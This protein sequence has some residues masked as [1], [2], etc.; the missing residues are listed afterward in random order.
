MS[1]PPPRSTAISRRFVVGAAASVPA[2]PLVGGSRA[3]EVVTECADWMSIDMEMERLTLRW[4][5]LD[6]LAM[7]Q[8]TRT[9]GLPA[10]RQDRGLNLEMAALDE[11]LN[12]L[13]DER[14]QRL[15]QIAK[16]PASDLHGVCG[17]LAV[18]ARML[19]GEGGPIHQIVEEAVRVLSAQ[20]CP[21]CGTRFVPD[22]RRPSGRL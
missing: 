4:A 13:G 7:R 10:G 2:L 16:H 3:P 22:V 19:D 8:R 17:K 18:A 5:T 15:C 21:G 12:M 20:H 11:R 14:E 6:A 9:N 1:A